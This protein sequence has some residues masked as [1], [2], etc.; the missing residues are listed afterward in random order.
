M[1]MS[2]TERSE[3]FIMILQISHPFII[4]NL[5][6]TPTVEIALSN[7]LFCQIPFLSINL[8]SILMH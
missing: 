2:S 3:T 7:F 1:Y 5:N 8:N 4:F 6:R